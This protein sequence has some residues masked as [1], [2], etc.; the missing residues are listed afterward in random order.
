MYD[1]IIIGGGPGGLAAGIYGARARLKVAIL[2]KVVAGGQA[3]TARE[4]VNYPGLHETSGPELSKILAEHAK[5]FGS[6][7]IRE[8][9]VDVDLEGEIKVIKTKKGNRYEAGAVILAVGAQPRML[10][11]PGERRLRGSGVSYCATCDADFYEGQHIIIVGNGDAALEEALHMT[12]FARRVTVIV[13]HDEGTVDCNRVSAE[14]ALSHPKIEFIWNSVLHEIKGEIEVESVVIKNL[15]TEQLKT[16]DA[17]GVFIYVG[18]MPETGFLKGKVDLDERGYIITSDIMETSVAGVYAV[19]DSRAKYLR[20]VVTAVSD[21]ATAAVAAE[22][23]LDEGRNF[24][25]AILNTDIPILVA[26]WDPIIEESM[27]GLTAL[28]RVVADTGSKCRLV[29][30][31]ISRKR[32]IAMKY[33]ISKTPAALLFVN[34]KVVKDLS[35]MLQSAETKSHLASTLSAHLNA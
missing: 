3:F 33:G 28:D 7:I 24:R 34:G 2:E 21:G 10:N 4:I 11:I 26:F 18:T 8:E 25:E 14:K 13:V 31:D 20:Q 17:Q 29:K 35:P 32:M 22:R 12:K 9:V 1:L 30:I 23:Y 5:D 27:A 16:M 19:G 15:K 6:E